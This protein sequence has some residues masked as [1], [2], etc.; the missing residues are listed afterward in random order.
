M[1]LVTQVVFS[2]QIGV[3]RQRRPDFLLLLESARVG[4]FDVTAFGGRL[5]YNLLQSGI[6]L[7]V[8]IMVRRVR[9]VIA[10]VLFIPGV[11][12]ILGWDLVQDLGL[13]FLFA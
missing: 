6:E 8:H 9:V 2:K 1:V 10:R 5:I 3:L 11:A 4:D 12:A 13:R 7:A